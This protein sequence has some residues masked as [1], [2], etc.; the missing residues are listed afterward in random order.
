M[1]AG[2]VMVWGCSH[3]RAH[4]TF[5]YHV[6]VDHFPKLPLELDPETQEHYKE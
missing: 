4:Q 2:R 1:P 5:P 3:R 6:Y